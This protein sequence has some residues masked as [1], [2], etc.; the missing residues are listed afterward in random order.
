MVGIAARVPYQSQLWEEA[1][2]D[3]SV[4]LQFFAAAELRPH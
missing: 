2:K 1:F 3:W 4:L